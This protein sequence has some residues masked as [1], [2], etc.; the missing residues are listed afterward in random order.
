MAARPRRRG[1]IL[2]AA[3]AGTLA[4]LTGTAAF[5][6]QGLSLYAGLFAP[7]QPGRDTADAPDPSGPARTGE[8]GGPGTEGDSS[9]LLRNNADDY[10]EVIRGL[11]PNDL[12]LP[13][14]VS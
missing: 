9:E 8:H 10:P 12:D 6:E 2:A 3:L 13:A 7:S 4:A 1:R 5:A 11:V 14:G